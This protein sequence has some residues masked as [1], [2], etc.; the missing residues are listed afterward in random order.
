MAHTG[1]K[2][3]HGALGGNSRQMGE[4]KAGGRTS[5][6]PGG[7]DNRRVNTNQDAS[8]GMQR[9]TTGGKRDC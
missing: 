5:N 4:H 7:K 2:S 1:K 8:N 3:N 9:H 6:K